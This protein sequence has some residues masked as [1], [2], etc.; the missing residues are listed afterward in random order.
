MRKKCWLRQLHFP[1]VTVFAK[2]HLDKL[3][4][5]CHNGSN[6]FLCKLCDDEYCIPEK[7]FVIN[8]II[9]NGLNIKLSEL[10]L[11]PVYGECKKKTN[12]AKIEIQ[13]IEALKKDTENYIFNILKS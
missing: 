10:K 12:G 13:R 5:S 8:K 6:T 4:E 7:G 9:Q 2:K 1:V 3:L 11:N